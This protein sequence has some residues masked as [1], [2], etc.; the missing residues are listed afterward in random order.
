M[1]CFSAKASTLALLAGSTHAVRFFCGFPPLESPSVLEL[2][3][4][5]D[6]VFLGFSLILLFWLQLLCSIVGWFFFAGSLE[7]PALF[8]SASFLRAISFSL[9]SISDL[10][11]SFSFINFSNSLAVL[12]FLFISFRCI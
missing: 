3:I 8:V 1:S 12:L 4:S 10:M 11:G 2:S 7:T 9:D 6:D 5:E